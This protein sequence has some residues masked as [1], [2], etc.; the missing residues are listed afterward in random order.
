[1]GETGKFIQHRLKI[2]GLPEDVEIFT[3]NAVDMIYEKTNG[4]P[5]KIVKACHNLLLDMI[6]DE[7]NVVQSEDVFKRMKDSDPFNV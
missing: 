7:K 3:E 2:A 5:R 4:Y 6:V 1:L